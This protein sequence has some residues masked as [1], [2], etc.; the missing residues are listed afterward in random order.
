MKADRSLL[1]HAAAIQDPACECRCVE[2]NGEIAGRRTSSGL[3][4]PSSLGYRLDAS[5]WSH[6]RAPARTTPLGDAKAAGPLIARHQTPAAKRGPIAGRIART[7]KTGRQRS[8]FLLLMATGSAIAATPAFIAVR[9]V[10]AIG[11][12]ALALLT[13]LAVAALTFLPGT[14]AFLT[15]HALLALALSFLA[16]HAFLALSTLIATLVS[17]CISPD[18]HR[19]FAGPRTVR[20]AQ[21][22]TRDNAHASHATRESFMPHV[23]C[24]KSPVAPAPLP[25]QSLPQALNADLHGLSVLRVVHAGAAEEPPAA[26]RTQGL[27]ANAANAP[28]PPRRRR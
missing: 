8:R 7:K 12:V 16:A 4:R 11:L 13:I 26:P 6:C 3:T 24:G 10:L 9:S 17:H 20:R 14:L 28:P 19:P 21:L 1:I 25:Q 23:D 22:P 2:M 18:P 27:K 15:A 5:R